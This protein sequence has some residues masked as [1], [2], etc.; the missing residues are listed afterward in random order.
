MGVNIDLMRDLRAGM[1]LEEALVKH[2]TNLKCALG[3]SKQK[4]NRPP[5]RNIYRTDNGWKIIKNIDGKNIYFGKYTRLLDAQLVHE[6]LIE[7][8]WDISKLNEIIERL[9]VSIAI[10]NVKGNKYIYK[11]NNGNWFVAKKFTTK[12]KYS[13]IYCGCYEHLDDARIIRDELVKSDW[14]ITLLP[15]IKR[16]HNIIDINGG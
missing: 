3:I 1:G 2:N 12:G 14:N 13:R 11:N 4:V 5:V 8:N 9:D 6:E 16:K 7:C 15:E 10:E